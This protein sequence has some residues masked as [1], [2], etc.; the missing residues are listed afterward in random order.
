[1]LIGDY[2]ERSVTRPIP[3]VVYFHEQGPAELQR[4]VEE[5]IIT[6]GY[7]QGDPRATS[8]GIHEQ[9]V[10]LVTNMCA[11]LGKDGGP[12]LPACWI[13]GFYGSGKSSFAKLLGLALDGVKVASGKTLSELL[14]AQDRSP[15]ASDFRK[16]WALLTRDLNAMAVVFDVGAQARDAEHIHAV[17][18]R[19]VQKRLGY[20]S[21]SSLVAEY[22]LKLELED[23]YDEFVAKVREVHGK[24]WDKLKDTQLAE[25]YFSAAIHALRPKLYP[26]PMAWVNCR[27]GSAFDAKRAAD[28]AVVAVQRMVDKRR[29]G[30]TL[31]LVVDEVSQYIHDDEDRMLALQSFVAALGQRLRGKAWILAT[32]QQ[33]LEEGAG[34]AGPIVKLKGRF[35]PQLRVHLGNSNIREVVHQRLLRKKKT[36]ETDLAELFHRHR[37]DIALYAYEGDKISERDFIEIYPLLPAHIDLLLRITSGLRARSSRVQGDSHEIRGLLQLL[38]D[39]FREQDLATREAGW[40]LTVDRV[41]DVLHTALDADLHMTLNRAM[42]FCQRQGTDALK[43]VVKTVAMLDLVQDEK[44]PTSAELVA[45]CLYAKL[46]DRNP[47]PEVQKALDI[48]V[49]EGFL[50]HSNQTGYKIEST[51]GQDW[52]RDRDGYVPSTEQIS[53]QVQDVIKEVFSDIGRVTVESLPLA[54]LAL[55]SDSVG[56]KDV[57]LHDERKPTAITVD[58]QLTKGEGAD[59]WIPRSSTPTY[60]DRIVWVVGE[61]D[62]VRYTAS[63]LVRSHR[64]VERYGSKQTSDPDKH[65]L[66]VQERNDQDASRLELVDV[67]KTAFMGG[68]IYFAGQKSQPRGEGTSF[69]SALS[70]FAQKTAQHLY[71]NPAAYTVSEKDVLY[72]IE[73]SDLSA[74]PPVFGDEKLGILSLD[75]S[76]YEAACKGRVPQEILKQVRDEGA[77]TGATLI[78]KLGGP[79][80]GVPPDVTRAAVV[81]LLR[82]GKI[83]VELAG[84]PDITSVRDEGARELLK[85]GGFRKARISEN[86]TEKPLPRDINAICGLFKEQLGKDLARDSNAI[87]DAVVQYFPDIRRRLN[88]LDHRFRRLPKGTAYPNALKKLEAALEN[89]CRDRRAEPTLL[90]VKRALNPLRDGLTLLRRMESELNED[91]VTA[92]GMA[93][94]V[95]TYE[96]PGLAAIGPSEAARSAASVIDA[97]LKV[98]RP[99]EDTSDLAKQADCIRSEYRER[100]RAILARHEHELEAA[101]ARIKRREGFD[102]LD[103]DQRHKVLNHLREGAAA[104]TDERA[105]APPLEALDPQLAVRRETAEHKGIQQLDAFRESSGE[106]PVVEVALGLAGREIESE[107]ELDRLLADLRARIVMELTAKHRVR[108]RNT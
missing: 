40:L 26:D 53:E 20:C 60:K 75:A 8:E 35:P 84:G 89:C 67:V 29:P 85:D 96:W 13:S 5:Y 61:Q 107:A 108:I 78:A 41:Y 66:L 100:R 99:W 54:W 34:V 48:L 86:T 12:E 38:G 28:E 57:R 77:M 103:A 14:V 27:S 91:A 76:R 97:H 17:V 90:A 72:L 64:M 92:V 58:F 71:P 80:H 55:Y 11:E 24:S 68:H 31:F 6:G 87:A 4:E 9:F 70:T 62:A 33:K 73:S 46:G 21:T 3:P 36:L 101:I 50:G 44:H 45:Q 37:P 16:A 82:G 22:E 2:F 52:Q 79:P 23:V 104:N 74:P 98:E 39:I 43:G 65:R 1:M 56:A 106:R 88:E 63:K 102:R 105:V 42:D 18:V 7:P 95:W 59:E 15:K 19:E 10:R 32:G 25:D 47:L 51:A 30:C 93:G 81:G 49:A 83:R 94:E 69:V